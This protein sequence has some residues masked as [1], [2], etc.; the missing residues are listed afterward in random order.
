MQLYVNQPHDFLVNKVNHTTDST[1]ENASVKAPFDSE[2]LIKINYDFTQL[3]NNES[4]KNIQ[5]VFIDNSL[6][7]G[8]FYLLNEGTGQ[9]IVCPA[10]E[11]GYFPILSLEKPKFKAWHD[12]TVKRNIPLFFLNFI[13]SQG[14]W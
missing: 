11:Q 4:I 2:P 13:I 6:N 9:T 5:N 10:K 7:D 1:Q 14:N 12:G 8:K 3:F